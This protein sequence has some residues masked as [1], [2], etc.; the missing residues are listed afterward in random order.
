[1]LSTSNLFSGY[2]DLEVLHGVSV[3]ARDAQVTGIIGPNGSGKSTLLKTIVGIIKPASG[4]VAFDDLDITGW[5]TDRI[6]SVGVSM[7]PQDGRTFPNLTVLENLRMG[8][9]TIRH[10]DNFEEKLRDNLRDSTLLEQRKK[11]LARTLS[12]G[13]RAV[14]GISRAL[15]VDPKIVLLDEPSI[16]LSSKLVKIMYDRVVQ[17]NEK[18]KSF[19]IVEQN[20]RKLLSV[21]HH[22]YVLDQGLI[23]F[24]GTP[25]ELR[26]DDTLVSRYLGLG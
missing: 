14:L 8:G 7:L 3:T 2:G 6:L 9:W 19:L 10:Q 26:R 12:G 17:L 18:G 5:S 13:E 22:V 23:R 16:G 11:Q 25:E 1:M 4:V 15:M 24:E 21:S 20:V